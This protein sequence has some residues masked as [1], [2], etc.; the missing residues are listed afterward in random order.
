MITP[1]SDGERGSTAGFLSAR[2]W[3]RD[4]GGETV[5][6]GEGKGK[7]VGQPPGAVHR[8]EGDLDPH[9]TLGFVET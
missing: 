3:V 7:Q 2:S 4:G 5:L 6:R 8:S 9:G 1:S